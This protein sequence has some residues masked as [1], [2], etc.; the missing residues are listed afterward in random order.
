MARIM[1]EMMGRF[2]MKLLPILLPDKL[3]ANRSV[4]FSLLGLVV[5]SGIFSEFGVVLVVLVVVV[6]LLVLVVS[7]GV[8][9]GSVV[10]GVEVVFISSINLVSF[11]SLFVVLIG[12][13]VVILVVVSFILVFSICSIDAD[14]PAPSLIVRL[15]S[16]FPTKVK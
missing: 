3:S 13:V 7:V 4:E 9:A 10:L 16:S 11:V 6:V 2:D 1:L 8:L 14:P 5:W 15:F 12:I